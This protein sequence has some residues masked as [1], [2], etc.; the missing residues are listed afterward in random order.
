MSRSAPLRSLSAI[1]RLSA[2]VVALIWGAA[3]VL[4]VFHSHSDGEVHRYCAE[5]RALEDVGEAAAPSPASQSHLAVVAGAENEE[6]H[7][8]CA[9]TRACRFGDLFSGFDAQSVRLLAAKPI[10]APTVRA[11]TAVI[12][13]ILVAPK[14]SPPV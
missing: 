1:H 9:F 5:H 10:A 6:Q 14:T 7:S 8:G 2:L 13:I 11:A 4:A 12:A 3:P